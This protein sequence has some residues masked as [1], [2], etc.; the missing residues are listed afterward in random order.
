MVGVHGLDGNNGSVGKYLFS[1]LLS[2]I[3][4]MYHFLYMSLY[5]SKMFLSMFWN[6][7]LHE[8]FYKHKKSK[9]RIGKVES[10]LS[11]QNIKGQKIYESRVNW[12]GGVRKFNNRRWKRKDKKDEVE[13][14][15]K[16]I[17][18]T[19]SSTH[20]NTH[21]YTYIYYKYTDS[22]KA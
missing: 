8:Q 16:L 17:M 1:N 12:N 10:K 18:A 21:T 4:N 19:N 20:T 7:K 2:Y 14:I 13:I 11:I 22:W 6:I 9:Y 5:L 15:I 3:L